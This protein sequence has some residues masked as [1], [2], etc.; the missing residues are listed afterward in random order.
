MRGGI[1][2]REKGKL[3]IST[4]NRLI[5]NQVNKLHILMQLIYMAGQ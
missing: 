3:T 2:L 5:V 4:W 1:S